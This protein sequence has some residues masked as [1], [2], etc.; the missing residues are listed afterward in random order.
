MKPGSHEL[1]DFRSK[2]FLP[3]APIDFRLATEFAYD[4]QLGTLQQFLR[5][6]HETSGR[7]TAIFGDAKANGDRLPPLSASG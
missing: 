7:P 1:V 6:T 3:A 5:N 2:N 4:I